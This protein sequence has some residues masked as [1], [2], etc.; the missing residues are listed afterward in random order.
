[1]PDAESAATINHRVG[2][3]A[4]PFAAVPAISAA[5]A[6]ARASAVA[7]RLRNEGVAE[8]MADDSDD[9][10]RNVYERGEDQ[11]SA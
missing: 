2:R 6:N 11:E 3:A 4:R 5:K 7:S 9:A 10:S 8:D 1:M